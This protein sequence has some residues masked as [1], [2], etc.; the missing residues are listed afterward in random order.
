MRVRRISVDASFDLGPE[1]PDQALHRP[2]CRIAERTDRM[3]FHPCRDVEKHVDL[4]LLRAPFRHPRDDP[5]HP[6]GSFPARGALAA[7]LV[8]VEIA[9]PRNGTDNIDRL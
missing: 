1:M 3:A 5:P 6:A 9:E 8:L 2:G 4:A 7:A